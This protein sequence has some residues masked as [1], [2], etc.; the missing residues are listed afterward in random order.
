VRDGVLEAHVLRVDSFGNLSLDASA[1][2]LAELDDPGVRADGAD[3][4]DDADG[5]D[6]ADGADD[7]DDAD[8]AVIVRAGGGG[9]HR[10]RHVRSFGE[11]QE[12]E[13]LLYEDSLGTLALAVNRGSAAALLHARE[14]DELRIERA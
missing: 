13:L 14:G 2:Q 6:G 9:A 8:G 7:A 1:S 10:A 12:G 11:V 4:A 5:A 3:D